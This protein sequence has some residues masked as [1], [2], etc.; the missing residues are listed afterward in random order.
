[1]RTTVLIC[2][3]GAGSAQ[4][5]SLA[6]FEYDEVGR[7][8]H[9]RAADGRVVASYT[10]DLVG[11]RTS[12]TDALGNRTTYVHD[13]FVAWSKRSTRLADERT[14]PMTPGIASRRSP[15]RAG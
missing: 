2:L 5:T 7:L 3:L 11:N 15:I 1:M 9:E 13:A 4:A 6:T 10:Y 14:W 8:L 12:V